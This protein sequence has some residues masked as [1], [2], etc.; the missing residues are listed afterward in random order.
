[1]VKFEGGKY[2][3]A[4]SATNKGKLV[5]NSIPLGCNFPTMKEIAVDTDDM[6]THENALMQLEGAF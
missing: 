5:W 6:Q 3:R 4:R 2:L 1:L